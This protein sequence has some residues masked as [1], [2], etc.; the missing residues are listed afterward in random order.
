MLM[1]SSIHF[2]K[3]FREAKENCFSDF[4]EPTEDFASI[5]RRFYRDIFSQGILKKNKNITNS[6]PSALR[7]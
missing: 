7:E 3:S 6:Y 2:L 4:Y 5:G 1:L